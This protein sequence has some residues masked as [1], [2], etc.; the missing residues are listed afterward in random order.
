M[1]LLATLPLH[2]QAPAVAPVPGSG[3]ASLSPR[4]QVTTAN[5]DKGGAISHWVYTHVSEVFP[6]AVVRRGGA[7][8]ELPQQP[9]NDIGALVVDDADPAGTLDRFVGNGAVDGVIVLQHGAIVYERHPGVAPDET[10]LLFSV[11]KALVATTLAILEDQGKV[12]LSKP[13]ETYVPELKR[14]AWAGT[15]LRDVADMRSGMA[16]DEKEIDSYRNPARIAFQL[17]ATLGWQ[18]RTAPSLEPATRRGDLIGFLSGMKRVDPPGTK[19]AYNSTNTALIAEVVSRV[20]G[21][22]L[23]DAASDLV[24]SKI[25]ADHDALLVENELGYPVAH[26]GLAATLRDVARFGLVFTKERTGGPDLVVSEPIVQRMF[27]ARGGK[28]DERGMLPLTYQ[29][30]MIAEH[31]ELVKGGWAGQLLYVNREK[32]VVVAWLG[33]NKTSDYRPEPLPCRMIARAPP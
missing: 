7:V 32:D 25:G 6:A 1:I 18:L 19:W 9:R 10:H 17:E 4:A 23:A 29:W 26:A 5:W 3:S 28:A 2:A 21:K 13:V 33:T 20:S 14:S 22:S 12:D 8:R 11:T 24:W 15:T 30:D 31:G 16:G 27:Q